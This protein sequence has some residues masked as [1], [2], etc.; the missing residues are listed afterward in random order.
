MIATTVEQGERLLAAGVN[1]ASA[2]M[3]Y[4]AIPLK[5]G[6]HVVELFVGQ[7]TPNGP[8][9]WSLSALWD[10]LHRLDKT[11]DFD[12][13]MDSTEL[14]EFLVRRICYRFENR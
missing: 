4:N 7:V 12:T 8:P 11:Y 13:K 6:G 14:I 3:Q 10:I 1:P 5:D 9:A 2:D